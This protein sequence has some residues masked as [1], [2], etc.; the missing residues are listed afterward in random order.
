MTYKIND[1]FAAIADPNRRE[2]LNLIANQ[3]M[4]VNSIARNF[5]ISRVAISKHLKI[6]SQS[7]LVTINQKG[8]ERR[9]RLNAQPLQEVSNWLKFYEQFWDNKLSTL[10]QNLEEDS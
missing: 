10:K 5:P 7:N 2:I 3:D 9:F 4:S 8:R 1:V 6:L